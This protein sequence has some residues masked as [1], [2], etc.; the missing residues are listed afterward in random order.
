MHGVGGEICAA[1]WAHMRRDI[2]SVH[3]LRDDTSHLNHCFLSL[4]NYG[5][6]VSYSERQ[7]VIKVG[8]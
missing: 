7:V 4:M 1:Q 2:V 3:N 6:R 5:E 8:S